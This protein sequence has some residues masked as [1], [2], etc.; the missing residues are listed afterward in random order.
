MIPISE[1]KHT[2]DLL[3]LDTSHRSLKTPAISLLDR[4]LRNKTLFD[5]PMASRRLPMLDTRGVETFETQI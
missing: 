4:N 3:H 2:P 5:C 1:N